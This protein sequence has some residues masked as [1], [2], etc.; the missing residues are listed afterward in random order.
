MFPFKQ[1]GTIYTLDFMTKVG[2]FNITADLLLTS[3]SN[4]EKPLLNVF[5]MKGMEK[6]NTK[7]REI[8]S[9]D[10][11]GLNFADPNVDG[12]WVKVR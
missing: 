9:M 4:L 10:V 3:N 7:D 2:G 1:N 5:L 12:K 8:F 11:Y 6:D